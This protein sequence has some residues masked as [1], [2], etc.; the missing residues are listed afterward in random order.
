M[1]SV[2]IVYLATQIANIVFTQKKKNYQDN[3]RRVRRMARSERML[4][5]KNEQIENVLRQTI[6]LLKKGKKIQI[7][8]NKH[9]DQL[10]VLVCNMKKIDLES[11]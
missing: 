7:E 2:I 3:K 8:Y 11:R 1:V 9:A 6:P 4:L 10:N 5:E